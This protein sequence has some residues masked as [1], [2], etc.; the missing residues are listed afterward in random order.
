MT[1]EFVVKYCNKLVQPSSA[2][3]WFSRTTNTTEWSLAGHE[4]RQDCCKAR[5]GSHNLQQNQGLASRSVSTV[6]WLLLGLAVIQRDCYYK[7]KMPCMNAGLTSPQLA[8]LNQMYRY[9][10]VEVQVQ[11]QVLTGRPTPA[12]SLTSRSSLASR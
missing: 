1:V 11:V 3:A 6:V 2:A 12:R 5:A 8:Q 7:F 9:S 4:S 10:T